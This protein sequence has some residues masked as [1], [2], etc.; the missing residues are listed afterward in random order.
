LDNPE[1][2]TIAAIH[3]RCDGKAVLCAAHWA[4]PMYAQAC[5][6]RERASGQKETILHPITNFTATYLASSDAVEITLGGNETFPTG[7]Q[8]TVLAGLTT[9][10]GGALSGPAVFTISLGGR[11]VSAK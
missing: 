10:A 2:T 4:R 6:S 1:L 5:C 9:A 3:S 11:N 7:G 8:I